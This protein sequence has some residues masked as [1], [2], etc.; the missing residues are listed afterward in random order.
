[1]RATDG[2]TGEPLEILV[3]QKLIE[4]PLERLGCACHLVDTGRE[5]VKAALAMLGRIEEVYR[6]PL[7]EME[8]KTRAVLAATLREAGL[9]K[10]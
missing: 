6:L 5:A 3:N 7:C 1:M 9:L 2:V 8:P 10:A 4:R